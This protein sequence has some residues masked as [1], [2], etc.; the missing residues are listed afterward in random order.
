M[1]SELVAV[2]SKQERR[3][4][5]QYLKSPYFNHR[6]DV[7]LLFDLL[8]EDDGMNGKTE[9]WEKLFPGAPY[10]D[11]QMRLLG[12]YLFR[13]LQ[14]YLVLTEYES[15]PCGHRHLLL[16]AYRKRKLPRHFEKAG[17]AAQKTLEEQA[18]RHAAY[19][20][21]NYR[22]EHEQY[23]HL[24]GTG[25]T[26]ELN[27]QNV[28]YQLTMAMISMKLRQACYLRAH[29]AVFKT[30]Y[31]IELLDEILALAEKPPYR[32]LPSVSLYRHCYRALFESGDE[33]HFAEFKTLLFAHG[34]HFPRDEMA[35]LY[36]LALNFCIK[37][38]NEGARQYL[39]EALDLYR[40]GLRTELLLEDGKISHFAYNNITGI[41]LRLPDEWA[42]AGHFV[43]TYQS[44]LDP[45][46][47]EAAH[48]LN[49]ARLAY[50]RRSYDEALSHL[51]RADY[52]DLINGMVA[53]VLQLKIYFETSEHELLDAHLKTMRMFVRRNKR[54]GY[55]HRNW[56]NIVHFTQKLLEL[57]PYDEEQKSALR[58]AIESEEVLTEREWLLEQLEDV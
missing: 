51:Q 11:Q 7:C 28:E 32:E 6:E 42:W 45:A 50:V 13:L 36:L 56:R 33:K 43:N 15:E 2:F 58:K 16:S 34:S 5:A 25:R 4:V 12:S 1:V 37:K 38:I 26:K 52:K 21:E 18:L 54:M 23:L 46:H 17:R 53:K 29:Q 20:F 27:L 8:A 49:S 19:H 55:H 39:R 35:S 14:Q 47:R 9:I 30:V 31:R 41:A 22:L 3:A 48:S 24:L 10:N 44:Y 40:E 57:N